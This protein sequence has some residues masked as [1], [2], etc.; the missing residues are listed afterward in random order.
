MPVLGGTPPHA[1]SYIHRTVPCRHSHSRAECFV[2]G[3]CS[4]LPAGRK[5]VC[6]GPNRR[7]SAG[8]AP[9]A[10]SSA[11][12][13]R[14]ALALRE[15]RHVRPNVAPPLLLAPG[16]TATAPVRTPQPL[17]QNTRISLDATGLSV[18]V[19]EQDLPMVIERIASLARIELRHPEGIPNRRVSIRFSSLSVLS[20]LKRLLRVAE[21][22]GYLLQ[23]VKQGNSMQ[24]QRII[25]LPEDGTA[26]ASSGRRHPAPPT[27]RRGTAS[28]APTAGRTSCGCPSA[29]AAPY[30]A[31]RGVQ[32]G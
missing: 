27:G 15:K 28:P 30:P 16:S 5:V 23:T 11:A 1:W 10:S 7:L 20:G 32:S 2:D 26:G 25:F 14:D 24:V 18:D 31:T 21:V 17:S 19:Q 4:G 8:G 3:V 12:V 13:C 29:P 6:L 9:Y 22:P